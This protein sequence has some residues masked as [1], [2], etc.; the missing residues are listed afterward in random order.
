MLLLLLGA[1]PVLAVNPSVRYASNNGPDPI[2]PGATYSLFNQLPGIPA[3]TWWVTATATLDA[4]GATFDPLVAAANTSCRLRTGEDTTEDEENYAIIAGQQEDSIEPLLLTML[5][6][7]SQTWTASLDCRTS[8]GFT[9][10]VENVRISAVSGSTGTGKPRLG[11]GPI[12]APLPISAG[13]S[14]V[15]GQITMPRGRWWITAKAEVDAAGPGV[16]EATCTLSAGK[17]VDNMPVSLDAQGGFGSEREVSLQIGHR[18]IGSGL[19]SF[20]CTA[21]GQPISVRNLYMVVLK[22]GRLQKLTLAGSSTSGLGT[23]FVVAFNAKAPI[24]LQGGALNPVLQ[25]NLPAGDW[26][27]QAKVAL[28]DSNTSPVTCALSPSGD[29]E[30]G[31]AA[32]SLGAFSG[33]NTGMFM[34]AAHSSPGGGFSVLL[35]CSASVSGPAVRFVRMTAI[36]ASPLEILD[37]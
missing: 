4:S 28:S 13:T 34:Q 6:T 17:D 11:G 2:I 21:G 8:A 5:H 12:A 24:A 25:L 19:T 29:G 18:F 27:I 30:R 35:A 7:D 33:G 9:V 3:G 1:A 22:A 15:V 14:A 26:L 20:R 32:S 36:S 31:D 23:P 10:N 37:L 16:S